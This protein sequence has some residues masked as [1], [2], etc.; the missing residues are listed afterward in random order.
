[1][2]EGE[3]AVYGPYP[4]TL[5]IMTILVGTDFEIYRA[6]AYL[7]PIFIARAVANFVAAIIKIVDYS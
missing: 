3:R 6:N 5:L 2:I 4:P 1:M 7:L